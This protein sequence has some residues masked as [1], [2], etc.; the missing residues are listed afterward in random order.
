MKRFRLA[1][2]LKVSLW[3]LPVLFVSPGSP[4]R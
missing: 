4:S 1:Q 2:Y 3:V